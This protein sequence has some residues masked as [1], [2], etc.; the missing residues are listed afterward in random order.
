MRLILTAFTL[1]LIPAQAMAQQCATTQLD[2]LPKVSRPAKEPLRPV[3]KYPIHVYSLVL[4]WTP[5]YCGSL[6]GAPK[7]PADR[8]QCEQDKPPFGLVVHGLWGETDAE[9]WPQWCA[10]KAP[11]PS[12]PQLQKHLCLMPSAETQMHEWKKHGACGPWTSGGAYWQSVARLYA[13]IKKPDLYKLAKQ[14]RMVPDAVVHEF[15]SSNPKWKG[16]EDAIRVQ[17][18]PAPG[19]PNT[20]WLKQVSLCFDP[21]GIDK[22][23]FVPKACPAPSDSN[24]FSIPTSREP[25]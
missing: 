16:H 12:L 4:S 17:T 9:S 5:A 22:G 11:A 1:A 3:S 2:T 13:S 24:L 6:K 21:K 7:N 10:T 14:G 18:M 8:L 25:G 15:T 19:K 20:Y 23:S